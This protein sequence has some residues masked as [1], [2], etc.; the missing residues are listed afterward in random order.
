MAITVDKQGLKKFVEKWTGRGKEDEDDRSYWIDLFQNVFAQSDVTDRIDFQ[1]KVI[2]FDG[3]TKRIDAYIPETNIIIEQ[4]SLG[5]ALDKPQAGHG[6]MTPYEQAK[7]YD[8][9]LPRSEKARWIVT[10][11]FE[12]IWV[13]DMEKRKPEDSVIKI[14]LEKLDKEYPMLQFLFDPQVEQIRRELKVSQEAGDRIGKVYDALLSLYPGEPTEEEYRS[15]NLFCVRLVFCYYAEDAEL[16]GKYQFRDYVA[17]FNPKHLRNG[18]KDLFRILDTKEEERDR[19]EEP[20]LLAF[21][22]VNGGLFAD[23]NIIIPQIDEKTQALMT[24]TSD[25][26]WSEI[27][28]TIF[29]AVFESTLN[30]ETRRKGGMH[31]TSIENIHKV[32][33]P[34]FLDDIKEE[35]RTICE[36]KQPN[37]KRQSLRDFQTKLGKLKFLDPACGSGNFLTETYL[38]L[39][40]IENEVIKDI[41]ELDKTVLDNQIALGELGSANSIIKVNLSQFYGIEINDFAVAVSKA[42]LWI[43]ESQMLKETEAVVYHNINFLPLKSYVNIV[44]GNALRV[45]WKKVIEPSE[46]SYIMGNPPFVGA[47]LMGAQQ[48]DDVFTIFADVKNNGNLDYVSCW[49]KKSADFMKGTNIRTALVSTNSICQGE[50]VSILWKELFRQG[51]HID[52]AYRTFRWDSEASLKAHVHCVIVGFSIAENDKKRVLYDEGVYRV[53][54]NIN[55]YL[56]DADNVTIDSRTKPI[57]DVPQIGIGNKPID[58]GNYLFSES[59]MNDFIQKEPRSK[60]YFR[61]WVGSDE[62]INGYY[63]YCLWLGECTPKELLSMPEC[64]KRV[65]AVREFRLNSSSST[66]RKIAEKPTRFHVE[67]MPQGTYILVPKVSSEKRKYIPIGFMTPD[68]L[69]SDLVFIIPNATLYHFAILTS[70]VHMAWMRAVAG[71]LE[72]RYRY[73]KDIVYNNFPWCKPSE[74]QLSIITSAAQRILDVR[75]AYADSSFADMYGEKMYL[76]NDLVKAH[77]ANDKAVMKAYGFPASMEEPEIVAELMKMYQKLTE[78]K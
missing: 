43:A 12:E 32:I 17:S 64:L 47:R 53:V 1:K 60:D 37:I 38:S 68:I 70:S 49:Y 74:D 8:N 67:N 78:E 13:Y 21:P 50:Q 26:N 6:G 54:N 15:L 75:S 39:R 48:K 58:G 11:N 65:D 22:Y 36:S 23:H 5:I 4:K 66:T 25:F 29:G 69:C 27:S 18:L 63:R 30:Q 40:R 20:E 24:E 7:M 55:G 19:T 51:V 41:I 34:L 46:C 61:K 76:Y 57:C 33:D 56:V 59:E 28:P 62:F 2:G 52:F 71:R 14:Y 45:D 44:E 77:E 9:G 16:F 31:Y 73:S 72:S 42:A 10:S 3:N 35:Y